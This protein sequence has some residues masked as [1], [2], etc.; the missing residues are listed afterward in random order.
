LRKRCIFRSVLE[1]LKAGVF[2]DSL[3]GTLGRPTWDVCVL[4]ICP[5]GFPS[6]RPLV[7]SV[8]STMNRLVFFVIALCVVVPCYLAQGK[9][10]LVADLDRSY[11]LET[12]VSAIV[13]LHGDKW[14]LQA[15]FPRSDV[16]EDTQLVREVNLR[17]RKAQLHLGPHVDI[18]FRVPAGPPVPPDYRDHVSYEATNVQVQFIPPINSQKRELL[19][20]ITPFV[21]NGKAYQITT[22]TGE[23]GP[24]PL[25]ITPPLP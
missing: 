3:G 5:S 14:V 24:I 25:R 19:I 20:F 4:F 9:E 11:I 17:P 18:A 23:K 21:A 22:P 13:T 2:L 12:E 10:K 8:K 6:T 15:E 16:F 1:G 7:R